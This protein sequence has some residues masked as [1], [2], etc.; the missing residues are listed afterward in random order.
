[1]IKRPKESHDQAT[2]HNLINHHFG[3]VEEQDVPARVEE[4][5]GAPEKKRRGREAP[6]RPYRSNHWYRPTGSVSTRPSARASLS[7]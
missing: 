1:M 5:F 7:I 2:L 6:S 4:L 3:R